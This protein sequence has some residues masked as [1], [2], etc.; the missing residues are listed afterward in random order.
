MLIS[1]LFVLTVFAGALFSQEFRATLQ[2]TVTDPSQAVIVGA[3]SVLR[4]TDTGVERQGNTNGLGHFLFEDVMPHIG[5]P[6]YS[7]AGFKT[8][9]RDKISLSVSQD[10]RLD[11]HA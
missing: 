5:E 3:A 11:L 9:V 8:I 7:A 1:R 10:A 2:G 4:N 6:I